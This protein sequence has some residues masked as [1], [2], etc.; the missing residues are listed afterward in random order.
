M[1]LNLWCVGPYI[2]GLER[3][4]LQEVQQVFLLS[5]CH[6]VRIVNGS[7]SMVC[8]TIDPWPGALSTTSINGIAKI[9]LMIEY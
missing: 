5:W 2:H 8:G 9:Q 1:F 3:Y 4:P 6:H 7:G